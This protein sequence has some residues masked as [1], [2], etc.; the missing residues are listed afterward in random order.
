MLI[1]YAIAMEI[2]IQTPETLRL[3]VLKEDK[4]RSALCIMSTKKFY[5][6][7]ALRSD[8]EDEDARPCCTTLLPDRPFVF[9]RLE[10]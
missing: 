6:V 3:V 5:Y 2:D 10:N 8:L 7:D 9:V 1:L 4:V